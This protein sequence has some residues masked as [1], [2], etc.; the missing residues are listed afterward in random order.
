MT[1]EKLE[2]MK[3]EIDEQIAINEKK[4]EFLGEEIFRLSLKRDV[5]NELIEAE[6]NE[7]LS[8]EAVCEEATADFVEEENTIVIGRPQEI[9]EEA[10]D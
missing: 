2:V 1:A 3:K 4:I 8:T 7:S 10:M 6:K 5:I 9:N